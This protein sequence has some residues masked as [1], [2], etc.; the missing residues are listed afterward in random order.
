MRGAVVTPL[1]PKKHPQ[2]S[3][4]EVASGFLH[5]GLGPPVPQR[6]GQTGTSPAKGHHLFSLKV[7]LFGLGMR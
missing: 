6:E 1:S 5:P 3:T 2:H 7:G 4:H